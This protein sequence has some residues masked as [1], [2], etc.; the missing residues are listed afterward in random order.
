MREVGE[1]MVWRLAGP[2]DRSLIGQ[3]QLETYQITYGRDAGPGEIEHMG[4]RTLQAL[5]SPQ[6]HCIE[7]LCKHSEVRAYYW[8]SFATDG[9][10][11]LM[12]IYVVPAQRGQG[13]GRL[14]MLR[15]LDVLRA[16]SVDRFTLNVSQQNVAAL[17]LYT[18][19]GAQRL[20]VVD[21]MVELALPVPKSS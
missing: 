21:G 18:R 17:A 11:R 1:A 9:P 14:V 19:Y 12:D 13:C 5:G 2:D 15:L 8:L 7:I 6:Q 3:A 4:Q 10:V 16:R 20:A